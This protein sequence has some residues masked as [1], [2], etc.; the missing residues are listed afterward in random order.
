MNKTILITGATDGI[1]LETVKLLAAAG[2]KLLLHGR[3]SEKLQRVVELL[4]SSA[5]IECYVADLSRLEDVAALARAVS[6]QHASLDVLIN[7]AG[8]YKTTNRLNPDGLDL[9]FVVNTIAPYL[10]TRQLLP[11]MNKRSRVVNLSSAAQAP[12]NLEALRGRVQLTDGAAYAQSKLAITMW[13]RQLANQLTDNG[14]VMIAVNPASMLGSKMV[15]EA[16]GVNGGDL[17]IG[18][19][20]VIRAALSEQFSHASGRYY[21][22]D[23]KQFAEPHPDGTVAANCEALVAALEEMLAS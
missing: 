18:A 14:P 11:L 13:T 7:N 9:R 15:K 17:T 16:F 6:E 21:D 20:I 23:A 2:H 4:P 19:E 1:G 12:V 22:N 10:L 3:N 5:E 8:V